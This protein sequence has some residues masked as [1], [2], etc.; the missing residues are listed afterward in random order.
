MPE[1]DDI[2]RHI[3]GPEDITPDMSDS[4]L[5]RAAQTGDP[6][7]VWIAKRG[8]MMDQNES[9]AEAAERMGMPEGYRQFCESVAIAILNAPHAAPPLVHVA[10]RLGYEWAIEQTLAQGSDT[11]AAAESILKGDNPS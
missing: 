9:T 4:I 2:L 3:N 8:R 6:F 10:F 1:E 11:V 7:T 5:D